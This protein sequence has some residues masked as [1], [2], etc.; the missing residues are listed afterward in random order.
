M[1]AD[2]TLDVPQR[3]RVLWSLHAINGLTPEIAMQ[4]LAS[5]DEHIRAWTIQLL[6]E[7]KVPGRDLLERFVILARNDPSPV[8]RL[9]LA[10]A[11]Q[12]LPV[13]RRASILQGLVGHPEDSLDPN[14]PM[15]LWYAAE[16]CMAADPSIGASLLGSCKIAKIL[17]F[18]ARRMA[19]TPK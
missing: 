9:Y 5:H 10:C 7:D 15:M 12:R 4:Q 2:N 1:L 17:E 8:V 11:L 14:L 6:C 19:S 13:D 3:L 18:V 16:P